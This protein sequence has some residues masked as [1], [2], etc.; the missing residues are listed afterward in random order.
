MLDVIIDKLTE[1]VTLAARKLVEKYFGDE[2]GT[3]S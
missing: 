2:H 3:D 1:S